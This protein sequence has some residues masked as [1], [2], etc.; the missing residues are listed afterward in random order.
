MLLIPSYVAGFRSTTMNEQEY[1]DYLRFVDEVED[2]EY[3]EY[4]D[5]IKC[6]NG[7]CELSWSPNN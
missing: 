2:I 5:Y 4:L 1:Y 3:Q 7:M 6:D